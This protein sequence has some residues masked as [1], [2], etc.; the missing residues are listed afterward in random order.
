MGKDK[1][2]LLV[3]GQPLVARTVDTVSALSDDLIV[4]ANSPARYEALDLQARLVPDEKRGVGALMGLYSGLRAALHPR[5]LVV[6]CD[7]P[8]LNIPLLR[9][10]LQLANDHDIV[11]PRVNSY[12][13]PLHAIYTK[14]CLPAIKE[15]LDQGRRQIIAFFPEVRVRFVE[16]AEINRF[17]PQHLSFLNVNTAEDWQQVQ[18]LLENF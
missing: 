18:N 14:N 9:Y 3:R 6:A 13:E 1:S 16:E 11:I 2:L 4:V 15:L 17:D 7:M 10:M 8:F 5:A 12:L